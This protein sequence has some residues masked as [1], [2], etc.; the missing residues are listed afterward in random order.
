MYTSFSKINDRFGFSTGGTFKCAYK[1]TRPLILAGLIVLG[2]IVVL[3][4]INAVYI[5]ITLMNASAGSA[6]RFGEIISGNINEIMHGLNLFGDIA[7]VGFGIIGTFFGMFLFV[8]S[9]IAFIIMCAI[10]RTGQKYSFAADEHQFTVIYPEKMNRT[11]IFEYDYIIG[12][13]YEEWRFMFAPKCFDVTV[14]TKMGDFTF[15]VVHTPMSKAN[16]IMETPFNII[17]ER[18]GLAQEDESILINRDAA[19]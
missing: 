12:L 10:L 17:R 7:S 15:R 16:G 19:R 1:N 6:Q 9:L 13:S 11:V 8:L 14:K 5:V 4:V 3:T 2:A 18:I